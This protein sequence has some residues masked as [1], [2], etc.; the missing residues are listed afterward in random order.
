[1]VRNVIPRLYLQEYIY[2]WI[3]RFLSQVN[4]AL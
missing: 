3:E 1:M 2:V 4:D